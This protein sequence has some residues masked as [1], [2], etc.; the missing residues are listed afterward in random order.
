MNWLKRA[1]ASSVGKK[2]LMAIT[3][4]LLCGFLVV[5][6]AGNLLLYK[7]PAAYDE[8]AHG[9]HSEKLAAP[10]V[11]AEIGLFG[12]FAVHLA[13]ALWLTRDNESARPVN[14]AMKQTKM[15][16]GPMAY[17]ASS[18]MGI[19]GL[20]VLLFLLLHLIDF[21]FEWRPDVDVAGLEP[22]EKAIKLL[23]NPI[24]LV[25]YIVGSVVLGYHLI[26][27]V[28]SAFQSLGMNHPKYTPWIKCLSVLFGIAVGIGFAS[29]P[30]CCMM[31]ILK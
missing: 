18:V 1:L 31:G 30:L 14:Y 3:G 13:L 9:I 16:Q 27:G 5:H 6:L 23:G 7:S 22:Y 11:L 20:I 10:L 4:L 2:V 17:P 12:L 19:T 26:H 8:Y 21:K 15:Q 24:T 29:F 25:V 28:Q